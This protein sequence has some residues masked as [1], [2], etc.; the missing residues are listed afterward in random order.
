MLRSYNRILGAL[1]R[2]PR[3]F[4]RIR[5]CCWDPKVHTRAH[6]EPVV[7][8]NIMATKWPIF[9]KRYMHILPLRSLRLHEHDMLANWTRRSNTTTIQPRASIRNILM[10]WSHWSV[11]YEFCTAAYFKFIWRF[12]MKYFAY[13]TEQSVCIRDPVRKSVTYQFSFTDIF[14]V[15]CAGVDWLQF[16]IGTNGGLLWP[17]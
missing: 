1:S 7:G 16:N 4:Q 11:I 5:T 9:A 13:R 3:R 15:L 6:R 2:A 14:V 17:R 10:S 12:C 8:I